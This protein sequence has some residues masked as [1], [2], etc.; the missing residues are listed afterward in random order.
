MRLSCLCI[1][2]VL[3]ALLCLPPGS[4]SWAADSAEIKTAPKPVCGSSAK[5]AIT[6]AERALASKSTESQ[7]HALICLLTAVKALEAQRLDVLNK[8][9]TRVLDVPR[10]P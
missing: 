10:S 2:A 7:G 9:E 6:A 4:A 3:A 8:H 1:S 5:E